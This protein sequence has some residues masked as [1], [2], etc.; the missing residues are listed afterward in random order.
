MLFSEQYRDRLVEWRTVCD[1]EDVRSIDLDGAFVEIPGTIYA[2]Y[3][4]S[5][6]VIEETRRMTLDS[7]ECLWL[8]QSRP[9][10]L[11]SKRVA[12]DLLCR[13]AFF[14]KDDAFQ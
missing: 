1:H 4:D 14:G 10:T 8:S 2:F 3:T 7:L 5:L 9:L 11:I 13:Q 12:V 6:E